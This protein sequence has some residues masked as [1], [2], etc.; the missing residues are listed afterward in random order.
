MAMRELPDAG[1]G[2]TF[3]AGT[4]INL[5]AIA[6]SHRRSS[7]AR[8]LPRRDEPAD[9]GLQN[10]VNYTVALARDRQVRQRGRRLHQQGADPKPVTDFWEDLHDSGSDVEGG[11]CLLAETYGDDNPLTNTL[12]RFRDH[13]LAD[14][15]LGRAVI[16][17]YYATLG[18]LGAIVHGHWTLRILSGIVL[19][20]LVV[21]ALL[22]HFLTLPGVLILF[23]L[24]ALRRRVMKSRIAARRDRHRRGR[25]RVPRRAGSRAR[26]IAVLGEP[27]DRQPTDETHRLRRGVQPAKWHVSIGVG[28][29]MPSIDAQS[30]TRNSAGQGP[31]QAM[32]GGYTVMP[33][34]TVDRY[35]W[36]GFGDLGVGISLGYMGKSANA[37]VIPSDPSD[38][39]RPRSPGDTT[40][41]RMIP[42]QVTALYRFSVLDDDYGIPIVPY[43][44]AGLGY[45]TWWSTID[46]NLSTDS[47]S[48]ARRSVPARGSS[49]RSASRSAPSESTPRPLDR[50]ETAGS[51]T[52]GSTPRSTPAGS[53]GSVTTTKLDVGDTTWFAGIELEF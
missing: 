11:F 9:P 16:D 29:Y 41:F 25:A 22:W 6:S 5:G 26:T 1:I 18:K 31:Y 20:P 43:V 52:P 51:R 19:A 28:P 42:L 45:Y 2:D 8:R 23:A 27:G 14:T 48:P 15:V 39:D 34:L 24:L 38:P 4:E 17:A 35:L 47:W 46:G 13:T 7:A 50:C 44:R 33:M 10:N 53:T 30:T 12:R 21:F 49:A 37:Y 40:A 3:D 36:R 32:F